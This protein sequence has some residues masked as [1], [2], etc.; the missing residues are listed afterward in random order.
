MFDIG[1]KSFKTLPNV[2]TKHPSVSCVSCNGYFY[3]FPNYNQKMDFHYRLNLSKLEEW[4]KIQRPGGMEDYE[5]R[6]F[7]SDGETFFMFTFLHNESMPESTSTGW[8]NSMIEIIF[9]R[10][11]YAHAIV[12]NKIYF[13]GGLKH[14]HYISDSLSSVKVFDM[15]TKTWS[16]SAPDIPKGLYSAAATTYRNRW[17]IVTGGGWQNLECFIF[18][19]QTQNWTTSQTTLTDCRED[20]HSTII[21]EQLVLIGGIYVPFRD[22][23]G[24]MPIETY[25][26]PYIQS[27]DVAYILPAWG[28]I[29]HFVLLRILLEKNRAH[30][31]KPTNCD[32]D[33]ND[34]IQKMMLHLDY[35]SFCSVLSFLVPKKDSSEESLPNQNRWLLDLF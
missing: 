27:I 11:I 13:I 19:V 7:F 24:R 31:L 18:D 30:V 34:L 3:I 12:R 33:F 29:G 14:T 28:I 2:P 15:S 32:E 1:K 23:L 16:A 4:E 20:H 25:N 10:T 21:E 6:Q 17:I 5:H 22:P 8:N 26:K 9:H 35:D